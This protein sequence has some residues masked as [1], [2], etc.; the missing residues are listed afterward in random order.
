MIAGRNELQGLSGGSG[1]SQQ[2]GHSIHSQRR[3]SRVYMQGAGRCADAVC[4]GF[5]SCLI[6]ECCGPLVE[7]ND[8]AGGLEGLKGRRGS[9]KSRPGEWDSEWTRELSRVATP[10]PT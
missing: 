1:L 3:E 9:E 2:Q 5:S 10:R 8:K 7:G 6:G 4:S